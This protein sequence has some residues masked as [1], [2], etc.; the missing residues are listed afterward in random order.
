MI[1]VVQNRMVR[2]AF[3]ED[4]LSVSF[5]RAAFAGVLIS[6]ERRSGI[7]HPSLS[8]AGSAYVIRA[9]VRVYLSSTFYTFV[10]P[11]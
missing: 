11:R 2:P 6:G 4:F 5:R 1:G 9:V 3:P 7:C 10:Q 8:G